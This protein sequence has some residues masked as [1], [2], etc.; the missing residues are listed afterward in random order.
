MLPNPWP[1]CVSTVD[2]TNPWTKYVRGAEGVLC[3]SC[4]HTG[5]D[6]GA[7][8]PPGVRAFVFMYKRGEGMGSIS[9]ALSVCACVFNVEARGGNGGYSKRPRCV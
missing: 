5:G 8:P 2:V 6:R 3:V 7:S 4:D 9:P 1:G